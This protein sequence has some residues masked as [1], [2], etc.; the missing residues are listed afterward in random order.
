[1]IAQKKG[2]F[3]PWNTASIIKLVSIIKL[4]ELSLMKKIALAALLGLGLMGTAN[5]QS[6]RDVREVGAA[7]VSHR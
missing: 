5:A 3:L 7:A 6:A 2:W 4:K 1:M